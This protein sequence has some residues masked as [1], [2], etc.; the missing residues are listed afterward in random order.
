MILRQPARLALLL[1]CVFGAAL[2]L[3]VDCH[4]SE[5]PPADNGRCESTSPRALDASV[6][7]RHALVEADDS[8]T[9]SQRGWLPLHDRCNGHTTCRSATYPDRNAFLSSIP[10]P[11]EDQVDLDTPS[12]PPLF[13]RHAPAHVLIAGAPSPSGTKTSGNSHA[14]RHAV[15]NTPGLTTLWFLGGM[16]LAEVL[17]WKMLTNLCGRC[18]HCHHWFARV[19]LDRLT[20]TDGGVVLP[21]L[22]ARRFRFGTPAPYPAFSKIARSQTTSTRRQNQCSMCLH[23]WETTSRASR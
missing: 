11:S 9:P 5:L 8:I 18:P 4:R 10:D 23:Q 3:G 17:L 21:K 19:E 22:R 2:A 12:K 16:L 6:G 1:W 15:K 20:P 14:P 13:L 7:R